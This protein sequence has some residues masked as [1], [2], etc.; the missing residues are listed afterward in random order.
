M[1]GVSG[2]RLHRNQTRGVL[3]LVTLMQVASYHLHEILQQKCFQLMSLSNLKI[4]LDQMTP[5][6]TEICNSLLEIL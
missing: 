3:V 5:E 6:H 4:F 2:E 1:C